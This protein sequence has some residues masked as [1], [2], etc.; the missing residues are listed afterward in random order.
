[1]WVIGKVDISKI[2]M[3]FRISIIQK[4]K[5][6]EILSTDEE[7]TLNHIFLFQEEN[8]QG[9]HEYFDDEPWQCIFSENSTSTHHNTSPAYFRVDRYQSSFVKNNEN[10]DTHSH[11]YVGPVIK[12]FFPEGKKMNID[13]ANK[14]TKSSAQVMKQFNPI[15][16][17]S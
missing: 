12:P 3:E 16:S 10:E 15:L 17:G 14:T 8:P 9:L 7:L 2:Y 1:M 4:C 13:W 5:S 11:N 6:K